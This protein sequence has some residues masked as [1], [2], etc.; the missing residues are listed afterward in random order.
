[1]SD[2]TIACVVFCAVLAGIVVYHLAVVRPNDR[3]I[4]AIVA[5]MG[6]DQSRERYTYCAQTVAQS[7]GI[8]YDSARKDGSNE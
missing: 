7:S 5:C 2:R 8:R 4:E 6:A 3:R 1:M